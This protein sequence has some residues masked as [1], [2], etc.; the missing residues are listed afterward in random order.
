VENDR[1]LQRGRVLVELGWIAEAELEVGRLL[2]ESPDSLDAMSLFAKIKHLKGELSQAIGCWAHI[3]ARSPHNEN[4]MMQL[5]ALMQLA[6]ATDSGASEFLALG[7]QQLARKPSAQLELEQ[8][9]ARFHERR[10]DEARA[11]CAAIA[12]RYRQR[13]AQLYKIAMIAGAWIAELAGDLA[14]ARQELEDL[15]HE[16]GFEH[17]LDRLFAL[18]RIY[19]QLGTPDTLEAAAKICRHV[20]RELEAKGVEKISLYSRLASLERR[21]GHPEV[22]A[23]LD[24]KFVAGVRRRMHRPTLHDVISVAAREYLPLSRLREVRVPDA[25]LPELGRREHA[26]VHAIRGDLSRARMLFADGGDRI[27]RRYIAELT[28]LEGDD[29]RATELFVQTLQEDPTEADDVLHVIEWLLD[30]YERKPTPVLDAYWSDPERRLCTFEI[31][32]RSLELAPLRA[33]TWRRLATLHRI[34]HQHDDAARCAERAVALAE[35]AGARDLPIGR[36]VAAGV[37]HFV[38]KAKGLLHEVWVHREPTAPGRGGVLAADDIHGNVTPELRAAIR[39]TFVAVR[40]YARA[41]F[42]HATV[43]INDYTYTYKLPKEDEPSGGLSAGLPS[44]LAFLSAFLQ[45]PVPRTVASTGTLITEAHDV[46]TIGRIGEADYKVK[47]A[48]HGNLH[49]LILPLANRVDLEQSTLVPLELTHEI[50]H[51]AADLDQAVKLVFGPDV[52]TRP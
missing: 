14:T 37:Y 41:K 27:D 39:N 35:A 25:Q 45:R 29:D 46:I 8:A 36:V 19:D 7:N 16:R 42:P 13:D 34:E 30:R 9:L 33:D 32:D 44:A 40:E 1:R 11:Q 17:D 10:P 18:A 6:R 38:G 3:H 50:V 15:G 23:E 52:F 5:S 12:A 4:V 20:L 28:A 22:A 31:L 24:A 49:S 51:Y 2:D 47:A 26:L 48:Y 21:A 43:D